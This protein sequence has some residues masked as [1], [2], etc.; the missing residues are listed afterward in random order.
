MARVQLNWVLD[1]SM[2]FP[3]NDPRWSGET[4]NVMKRLSEALG[5]WHRAQR[6]DPA[7]SFLIGSNILLH[8][9]LGLV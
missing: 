3:S 6:L 2:L 4:R 5:E 9:E 8:G 7:Q 1:V